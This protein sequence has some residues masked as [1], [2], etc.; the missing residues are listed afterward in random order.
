MPAACS[1]AAAPRQERHMDFRMGESSSKSSVRDK[2]P[3]A[4]D[5][6]RHDDRSC[7]RPGELVSVELDRSVEIFCSLGV[8]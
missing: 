8:I 5:G 6:R 7:K 4:R 2:P 3:H 1:I